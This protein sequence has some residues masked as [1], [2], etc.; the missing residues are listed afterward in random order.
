M[1]DVRLIFRTT[2]GITHEWNKRKDCP[3]NAVNV[4][5]WLRLVY[6]ASHIALVMHVFS[7]PQVLLIRFVTARPTSCREALRLAATAAEN[8]QPLAI[9][10]AAQGFVTSVRLA[11]SERRVLLESLE[12]VPPGDHLVDLDP[13]FLAQ[14]ITLPS[15]CSL[16]MA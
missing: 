16:T 5:V 8:G 1:Y 15:W 2:R 9:A 4:E 13:Q 7:V 14:V 3:L 11:L 12:D 10:P 6:T